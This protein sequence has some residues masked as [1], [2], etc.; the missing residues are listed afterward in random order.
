M[1]CMQAVRLVLACT[2]LITSSLVRADPNDYVHTPAVEEGE[3]D[4]DFKYGNQK[5]KDGTYNSA[6]SLEFGVAANS[7]WFT[8]INAKYQ[9]PIGE[10]NSF[11]AWEWENKFQFLE[12][13]E[14]PIDLGFFAG[15]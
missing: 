2:T 4:I 9:K 11:D 14:Y 10:S 15:N 12:T 6:V 8:E 13:G 3:R 1:N 5:N 7:W